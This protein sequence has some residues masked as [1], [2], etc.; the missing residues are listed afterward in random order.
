MFTSTMTFAIWYNS[1]TSI[2]AHLTKA[3]DIGRQ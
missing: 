3:G 1:C 2:T